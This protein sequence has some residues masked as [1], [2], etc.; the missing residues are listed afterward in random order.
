MDIIIKCVL[1]FSFAVILV[2]RVGQSLTYSHLRRDNH[3]L[4]PPVTSIREAGA[5]PRTEG[6]RVR[7]RLLRGS[8]FPLSLPSRSS[9]TAFARAFARAIIHAGFL[10]AIH[11]IGS[12]QPDTIIPPVAKWTLTIVYI[13]ILTTLL[14]GPSHESITVPIISDD[15]AA[16]T[17][18]PPELTISTDIESQL[19]DLQ[20]PQ[21]A[22]LP[23]PRLNAH[24]SDNFPSLQSLRLP[25]KRRQTAPT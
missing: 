10:T 2:L 21:P 14:A 8:P 18:D 1:S 16:S 4:P 11:E 13:L 24:S 3:I 15:D 17:I 19:P 5:P 25:Q 7:R 22:H 23:P 20:P 6:E 9:M 12:N